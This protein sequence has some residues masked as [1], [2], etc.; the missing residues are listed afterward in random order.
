MKT[1]IVT[2]PA[3]WASYL[4]NGDSSGITE[5]D[6]I[7][8]DR[9]LNGVDIVDVVRDADGDGMDPYFTWD[10]ELHGG[11]YEGGDVLDYVAVLTTNWELEEYLNGNL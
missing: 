11:D 2:A 1:T 9:Y 5:Q 6:Q 7:D 3:I 8:A 4:V 10:Y